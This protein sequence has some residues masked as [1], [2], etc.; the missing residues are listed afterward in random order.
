M[1]NHPIIDTLKS[2]SREA[3]EVLYC[4]QKYDYRG[5]A[6]KWED[7]HQSLPMELDHPTIQNLYHRLDRNDNFDRS[8]HLSK[9]N[10][11][12][13]TNN[14]QADGDNY[15]V[16]AFKRTPQ[17]ESDHLA[18][19]AHDLYNTTTGKKFDFTLTTTLAALSSL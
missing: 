10:I 8:A 17:G 3:E 5:E 16:I 12:M 2:Y 19:L 1:Q 6:T 14:L 9:A 4:L 11:E 18:L 15:F 7:P 13:F